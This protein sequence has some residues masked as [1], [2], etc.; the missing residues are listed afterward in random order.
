MRILFTNEKRRNKNAFLCDVCDVRQS[1]DGGQKLS[2]AECRD[3]IARLWAANITNQSNGCSVSAPLSTF[4]FLDGTR[5]YQT[6]S[7]IFLF[8]RIFFS[9]SVEPEETMSLLRCLSK[10]LIFNRNVL[11]ARSCWLM[12]DV[13]WDFRHL[14]SSQWWYFPS[15]A[16]TLLFSM[17]ESC[18][19]CGL[20]YGP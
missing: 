1:A 2:S 7:S 14:S 11:S 20:D 5:H 8:I 9:Y 13:T 16:I 19:I 3:S 12:D 17:Y 18:F 6:Y 4:D 10:R 15:L